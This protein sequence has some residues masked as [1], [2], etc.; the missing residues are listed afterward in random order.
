MSA[1]LQRGRARL[2]AGCDLYQAS[3]CPR[4]HDRLPGRA[5]IDQLL[6]CLLG[7]FREIRN[8]QTVSAPFAFICG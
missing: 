6:C 5:P 4:Q 2:S 7:R 8:S 1:L 3:G